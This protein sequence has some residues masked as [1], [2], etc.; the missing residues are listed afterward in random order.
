MNKI[1]I[2]GDS[3]ATRTY[4]EESPTAEGF[5][6][7]IY[8]LCN[9]VYN[10]KE[11]DTLKRNWGKRYHPW[12]DLLDADVFGASGSDLYYSYNQF[13]NNHKKYN[14]CIFV[15]TSPLRY[16]SNIHGWLHGASIEDALEGIKFSKGNSFKQ[17]YTSLADFFKNIYYKD[18]DRIELINQAMIDS[19]TFKRPDTIFIN[20][21]PDLKNVYELELK[22]WNLTH[23]E[24]QDYNKYFDLRQCHMTNDN[25]RILAKFVLDN[26]DK[27]GVLD[28]SSIQWKVPSM[29]DRSY[30]LPNTTDL[31]ARLI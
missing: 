16:S 24:S 19:I 11:I 30:Y 21:F 26:L 20:A 1:A 22:A 13:I 12:V 27:S 8:A 5:L 29:E 4:T 10:K 15:I 9:K 28:L 6:K 25:N 3:F 17:Y 14:K 7:E 2:F 23:D 18:I 31:F